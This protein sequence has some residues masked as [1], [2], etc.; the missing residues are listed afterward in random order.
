MQQMKMGFVETKGT[1]RLVES[2]TWYVTKHGRWVVSLFEMRALGVCCC[3][4]LDIFVEALRHKYI[5]SK[6]LK[7]FVLVVVLLEFSTQSS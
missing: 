7:S 2:M 1:V 5:S 3:Q 6:V 4:A